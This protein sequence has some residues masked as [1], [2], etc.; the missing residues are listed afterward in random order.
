M[1]DGRVAL[2][3]P[4][5]ISLSLTLAGPGRRAIA[6]AID[7]AVWSLAVLLL[8][9]VIRLLVG[10]DHSGKGL[11]LAGLFIT[12][13][14]Y[15]VLCEVY[16][17]GR[18]L[19]KRWMGLEV[20]RADGLP[21]GWRESV[22]RNLLMVADFLPALYATGLIC[23]ISDRQFRRLGDLVAGTLVIYHAQPKRR[24]AAS[25]VVPQPLPWPLSPREQRALLDLI[26]RADRLS[27]QR[28]NE[29]ADLAEPLTGLRGEA[30][31][32]RLRAFAAG[33]TR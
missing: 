15:P 14:G 29:L 12:Y 10:A 17:R 25:D 33:L 13:W 4:E 11:F 7:L 8:S 1:Q 2:L 9:I 31:L 18:T 26:E 22:L 3:T 19:G 21:V 5:G 30:S 32:A 16:A 28:L 6:W 20:V 24:R 27:P 23:M